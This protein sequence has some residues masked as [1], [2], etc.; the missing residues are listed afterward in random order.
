MTKHYYLFLKV[1]SAA[2][3]FLLPCH[4]SAAP[5]LPQPFEAD[6]EAPSETTKPLS[7]TP[8]E[9][10]KF[11][12]M[13]Q[14]FRVM[15]DS[16]SLEKDDPA[17]Q[18]IAAASPADNVDLAPP[19]PDSL[20]GQR[21]ENASQKDK[22]GSLFSL[23]QLKKPEKG[24][25]E[26]L[27]EL[28]NE[29]DTVKDQGL[30]VSLPILS[31]P[32]KHAPST[33]SQEASGKDSDTDEEAQ[34]ASSEEKSGEPIPKKKPKHT[35][36]TQKPSSLISKKQYSYENSHLPPVVYTEEYIQLLFDS[37]SGG[38]I[39]VL[40]SMVKYF[41]DTEVRDADGN[42]PLIYATMAGN[43][44][45]VS[46]MLGMDA[47]T[48]AKNFDGISA[49]YTAAYVSRPDLVEMLLNY[50][51]N[52][53]I[54]DPNHKTPLMLAAERGAD[55]I[56]DMLID[57][58]ANVNAR[59]S[60]GDTALHLAVKNNAVNASYS[61]ITAGAGIETRNFKG[62]TPLMI[63][64]FT[65]NEQ[66]ATLLLNAGADTEKLDAR[67]RTAVEI[68]NQ[69]KA[70]GVAQLIEAEDIRRR[71][72]AERLLEIR[73]K[74]LSNILTPA[75]DKEVPTP[76][77]T[78]STK[79]AKNTFI[80]IP[81]FKP[82]MPDPIQ[83]ESPPSPEKTATEPQ[84]TPAR[85]DEK[86]DTLEPLV[87]DENA[88]KNEDSGKDTSST[89]PNNVTENEKASGTDSSIQEESGT[90]SD[91]PL[92]PATTIEALPSVTEESEQPAP[93]TI[94]ETETP[95]IGLPMPEAPFLPDVP[96]VTA[97]D[98][99]VNTDTPDL[100]PL[101][102][103]ET[104][105]EADINSMDSVDTNV[106]MPL[107]PLPLLP[108]PSD[109]T[110]DNTVINIDDIEP[111][112]DIEMPG[113]PPLPTVPTVETEVVTPEPGDQLEN[114]ML[115][116]LEQK[117][118]PSP[119]SATPKEDIPSDQPSSEEDSFDEPALDE[120]PSDEPVLAPPPF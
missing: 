14:K 33:S 104:T 11:K 27:K 9:S 57:K 58:G 103:I 1:A 84:S 52:P 55:A 108:E 10:D 99:D 77:A 109:P 107:V 45:S 46:A 22:D 17:Y 3:V 20:P 81:R 82:Q 35:Y 16:F 105:P 61:L 51:A 71:L 24:L 43:A 86:L 60:N 101:P 93:S 92:V 112:M 32:K 15:T 106:D 118:S 65:K 41:R 63:T 12:N 111:D 29:D 87:N 100:S 23:P 72:M 96:D 91:V 80:P 116:F 36:R 89:I 78:I 74:N 4:P 39:D 25:F 50:G 117:N 5:I 44:R 30:G 8:E 83:E 68:A 102:E 2:L 7:S 75:P 53:D 94:I 42:T 85:E 26:V 79:E 28:N 31:L 97:G 59:M 62:Y 13:I 95:D 110:L 119:V 115:K 37:A 90:G 49:L 18:K 19:P 114:E 113:V 54:S 66:L 67:G 120:P 48:G 56:V 38:N 47:G 34:D 21:K 73:Q 6:A 88:H 64:G 98:I 70:S 76:V 40:R 69:R